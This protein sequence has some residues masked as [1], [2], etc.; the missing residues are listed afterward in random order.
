RSYVEALDISLAILSDA[1]FA[2]RFFG[3]DANYSRLWKEE[4]GY[5]RIY[6]YVKK[7]LDL[8]ELGDEADEV[9]A[10][11][12]NLKNL[13][14]DAVHSDESGAF[15]SWAISPLGWPDMIS[16]EP[17]GVISFHAANH[18]AALTSE[19]Y[20]F[21]SI[22]IKCLML[23]KLHDMHK[24]SRDTDESKLFFAH[25]MAFQEIIHEYELADGIDILADGHI[26][27]EG[28]HS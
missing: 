8:A 24:F 11:K 6:S 17:H 28:W 12:R 13:L 15:R 18:V 27:E 7:A 10:T 23:E 4:I 16:T 26:P 25:F 21:L 5:G 14:S 1:S 22:F 20:R 19:T 2:E 9:I 3:D